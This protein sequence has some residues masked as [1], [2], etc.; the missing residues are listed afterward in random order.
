MAGVRGL[1]GLATVGLLSWTVPVASSASASATDL[2]QWCIPSEVLSSELNTTRAA[3]FNELRTH[4]WAEWQNY[5]DTTPAYTNLTLNTSGFMC[6][7]VAS[8]FH[9][10]NAPVVAPPEV[11]NP[12]SPP[13]FFQQAD[14]ASCSIAAMAA[15]VSSTHPELMVTYLTE[16]YFTGAI[17]SSPV[18]VPKVADYILNM[19]PLDDKSGVQDDW[20]QRGPIFVWTTALRAD[21]NANILDTYPKPLPEELKE[22]AII[23]VQPNQGD[24]TQGSSGDN[25][26]GVVDDVEYWCKQLLPGGDC[27]TIEGNC[28]TD[29]ASCMN[30]LDDL[31]PAELAILKTWYM[32][33]A[34]LGA[35]KKYEGWSVAVK[36]LTLQPDI[37]QNIQSYFTR[38]PEDKIPSNGAVIQIASVILEK[39]W[40]EAHVA[41]CLEREVPY[42]CGPSLP[43]CVPD[44]WVYAESC[45]DDNLCR[46]WSWGTMYNVS[47][48]TL[49][50]VTTDAVKTSVSPAPG[51]SPS[52]SF[53]SA[54]WPRFALPK[55]ALAAAWALIVALT[56][57]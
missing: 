34:A 12:P 28:S 18:P 46:V 14:R 50:M 6:A 30:L 16:L 32:S 56:A 51:P 31:L 41:A 29:D 49:A 57:F 33:S 36:N 22:H 39:C 8:I 17:S 35:P 47:K 7:V 26:L 5:A 24:S 20:L 21:R 38:L 2:E 52:S 55:C 53:L 3:F 25:Y 23:K 44:H 37:M 45:D 27:G 42:T 43:M 40:G 54:S 48:A 13:M 19:N 11:A 15:A 10:R 1:A 4:A 9:V